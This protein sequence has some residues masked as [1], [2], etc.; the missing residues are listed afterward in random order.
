MNVVLCIIIND[1]LRVLKNDT[2]LLTLFKILYREVQ[3]TNLT[4]WIEANSWVIGI[5]ERTMRTQI[6]SLHFNTLWLYAII[7]YT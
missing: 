4:N 2:K 1:L 7:I 3:F 5:L 6:A